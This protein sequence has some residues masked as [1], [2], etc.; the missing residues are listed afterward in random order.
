MNTLAFRGAVIRDRD[1]FLCLTDMWKAA[2]RPE[3]KAVADWRKLPGCERFVE[4][5]A[6][7]YNVGLSHVFDTERGRSGGTWAHWQIALAYAQ[8]LSP[9]FHAWCNE[10]VRAHMEG[11]RIEPPQ[12][13]GIASLEAALRALAERVNA[14]ALMADPR[15]AVA[16]FISMREVLNRAGAEPK[17]RRS[18]Q[19]R[20][21]R[22]F[23]NRARMEGVALRRDPHSAQHQWLF[24]VE[25]A[26]ECMIDFGNGLVAE[27][28]NAIGRQGVLPFK[29]PVVVQAQDEARA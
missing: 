21:S 13:A 28:N 9:E 5:I 18:L 20:L 27:H 26:N 4:H 24:P 29:K 15:V 1:E 2:G 17:G 11:R 7:A 16:E 14:L 12:D 19:G 10:V 23:H 3:N 25:F 22:G 6:A 8:Y